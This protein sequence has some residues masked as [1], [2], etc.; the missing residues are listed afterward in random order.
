MEGPCGAERVTADGVRRCRTLGENRG[1]GRCGAAKRGALRGVKVGR[2]GDAWRNDG[3]GRLTACGAGAA[4]CWGAA[5]AGAAACGLLG[6]LSFAEATA[7]A[8]AISN[9]L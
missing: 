3:A 7:N 4:L 1:A 9:R 5:R 8:A 2:C 6:L